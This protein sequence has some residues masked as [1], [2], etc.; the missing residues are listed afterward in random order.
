[1]ETANFFEILIFNDRMRIKSQTRYTTLTKKHKTGIRLVVFDY[2]YTF[3]TS[4]RSR[5]KWSRFTCRERAIRTRESVYILIITLRSNGQ[6]VLL[7]IRSPCGVRVR[8]H[9]LVLPTRV[10]RCVNFRGEGVGR[11]R[12]NA[13]VRTPTTITQHT[14]TSYILLYCA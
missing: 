7:V 1:L 6:C 5:Q 9:V 4:V 3:C 10:A 12:N 2:H 8:S 11:G 13:V 14:Y